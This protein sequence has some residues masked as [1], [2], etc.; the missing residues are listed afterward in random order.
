MK[1]EVDNKPE[2]QK[3][4]R[5]DF[6]KKTAL[7][8][9]AMGVAGSIG[10][11][12]LGMASLAHAEKNANGGAGMTPL[13]I[14]VHH[15]SVPDM[16]VK[17]LESKNYV[18]SHGAGYPAW[19]PE[20]SLDVMDQNGIA[21]AVT[22]ISSP[23]VYIGDEAHAI[24]FSRRLNGYSA[25]MVQQHPDRFG[26]FA[27]LPMPIVD[28]SI[29]EAAYA[30]DTLNADG[31]VLLASTGD[32]FLGDQDFEELMAELDRRK[33]VVFIHPNIHSTSDK[34]PLNIPGFFIEF[35]FDTTRAVTNL[36]FSGVMER[37]PNIK[38]IVAHAG[39]TVPY[40]AWRL[41]LADILPDTPYAKTMPKGALAY[42]KKLYYDTALSPSAYAMASLLQLV[43]PTQI[44]F[45][46]DF[47]F[48]PRDLVA[49]E[50]NDLN[51]LSVFDDEI[52]Q[53][54]YRDNALKLFPRF[55]K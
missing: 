44:L 10:A 50:V 32:R 7:A 28:A 48:A 39:A 9:G 5:R 37:Y 53:M 46:S 35:M 25:K 8:A 2:L 43:E 19:T 17:E 22:S 11:G 31:V 33:C 1:S 13:K 15:H 40:L 36:V 6:M 18:P 42:L 16:Y 49:K 12:G 24:D 30:L 20:A 27:I 29:K 51:G 3:Y 4:S 34:L 26:F 41:S 23:G 21:A 55:A 14:D 54:V 47:P 45:G 38:W 52:R